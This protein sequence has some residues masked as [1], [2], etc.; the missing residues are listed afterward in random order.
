[1]NWKYLKFPD[2]LWLVLGFWTLQIIPSVTVWR[3]GRNAA[4]RCLLHANTLTCGSQTPLEGVVR[5]D[6][7]HQIKC[8]HLGFCI[9]GLFFYYYFEPSLSHCY[10]FLW[11]SCEH[12]PVFHLC[13]ADAGVLLCLPALFFI[14]FIS[15][16]CSLFF[17]THG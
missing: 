3:A 1:M 5:T 14:L 9:S 7:R 8:Y 2:L 13:S 16:L 15:F 6:Y 17:S 10:G 12:P 4:G 11:F